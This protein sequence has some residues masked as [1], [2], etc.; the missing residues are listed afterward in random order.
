[1]PAVTIRNI[2]P[3][4]HRAL[5]RRAAAHGRSAEAEIRDILD[6]AVR[7]PDRV[8]I[9]SALKAFGERFG[10]LDL[11]IERDKRPIRAA[12]LS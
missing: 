10:G 4:T 5:K 12:D 3:E 6:A 9:G 1:M 7:P 8:K 11:D 2:S